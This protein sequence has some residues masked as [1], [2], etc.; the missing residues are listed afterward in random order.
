MTRVLA[1]DDNPGDIDLVRLALETAEPGAFEVAEVA[2]LSGALAQVR[3]T[4]APHVVLLDLTLPDAYGLDG[5]RKVTEAAPEL[6]VVV[7]TGADRALGTAAIQAGAQ[8]YLLKGAMD[9]GALLARALR[10]AIDRHEH[11]A[12]GRLLAAERAAR[13]A[14]E[15][16]RE[17]MALLAHASTVLAT[18]L[19]EHHALAA[20]AEVVV[21]SFAQWCAIETVGRDDERR[22]WIVVHADPARSPA[23][24]RRL[25]AI[26]VEARVPLGPA[27][28]GA[29]RC[30]EP[31]D[32]LA[33]DR[34]PW[35]SALAEM[36]ARS[37]L[38]V[39][40]V[41]SGA[42][43]GVVV[44]AAHGDERFGEDDL[45]MASEIGRRAGS[46]MANC[47]LYREARL[48]V[49]ARDE[50]LAV[51][52]HELRTP[53]SVLQLKLQH[54]AMRQDPA[55]RTCDLAVPVDYGGAMRQV[56][57][58]GQLIESLLDVSRIVGDRTDLVRED[59]D[60]RDVTREAI[61]RLAELARR[62]R[63]E[64]VLDCPEPARGSWDRLALERV[65]G[66]LVS[67][68]I[69]F[70]AEKPVTVRIRGD[71]SHVVLDVRDRGIGIPPEDLGRIFARFERAV[72]SRH[73]GGLGLGLYITR[74]LVEQHGGEISV[75]STP[76][77]GSVFTVRLP[78]A[79]S[80]PATG[81]AC[82]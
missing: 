52:A 41:V 32:E 50:F 26:P 60:L 31:H 4:P 78:R 58:L 39:P 73:F 7:L 37:T 35:A 3:A 19:D 74:R 21:D 64:V 38:V 61:D 30:A 48:A 79:V 47:R 8:D 6:P 27:V 11:A 63:S 71:A 45:A 81:G 29:S 69:K 65:L 40:I 55:C 14:A 59:L 57:R 16:G 1:V 12:R 13:G 54:V 49:A 10:Y 25:D 80:Q 44:L 22:E 33:A 68:A 24:R 9:E 51:A 20:L 15:D 62:C 36:G 46:A 76:G 18:S 56:A 66:H 17:R 82:A 5:L 28:I 77:A 70:G 43:L 72:S 2:T 34:S 75:A 23:L 42:S 53:V 67:N